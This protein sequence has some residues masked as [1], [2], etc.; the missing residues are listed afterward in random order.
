MGWQRTPPLILIGHS[1]GGAVVT[2]VANSGKLGDNVLGYAVL[3]VVEGSAIDALQ[4]M[5]TY[6]STR[7]AGFPTL[8][9][10]ID[11][12]IRSRTIRNVVSARISVPALLSFEDGGSV[13]VETL[14][15]E[16]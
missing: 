3:D 14:G 11:W 15:L 7:P 1:L 10:G 8:Q 9:S 6:L 12:H 4:S 5:Q 2:D 16:D 13:Q